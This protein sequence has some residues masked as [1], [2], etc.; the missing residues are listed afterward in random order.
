VTTLSAKLNDDVPSGSLAIERTCKADYDF[1]RL[2][3]HCGYPTCSK[4]EGGNFDRHFAADGVLETDES[5]ELDR[6]KFSLC[7][8]CQRVAYCC[9]AH[10][11]AHWRDHHDQCGV[12]RHMPY[13]ELVSGYTQHLEAFTAELVVNIVAGA[14]QKEGAAVAITTQFNMLFQ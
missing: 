6:T 2:F 5:T 12:G 4:T 13:C 14:C 7:S 1:E 8:G 3:R 9:K 11:R 10:Q